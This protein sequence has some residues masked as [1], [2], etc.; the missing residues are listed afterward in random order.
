[1]RQIYADYSVCVPPREI[2]IDEVRFFYTPMID[3]L[4]KL[5]KEAGKGGK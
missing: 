3:G 5:Q 2:T 4:C 1:M